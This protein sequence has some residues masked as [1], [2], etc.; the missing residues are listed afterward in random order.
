MWVRVK[1]KPNKKLERVYWND[2]GEL[3]LQDSSSEKLLIVEVNAP[4][5]EGKAN[6]AVKSALAK[7][8]NVPKSSVELKKGFTSSNKLFWVEEK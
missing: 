1:V 7:F 8:F 2:E 5:A 6:A 3:P 4:P